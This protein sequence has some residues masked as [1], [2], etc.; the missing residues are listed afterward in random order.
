MKTPLAN[1][2]KMFSIEILKM[3]KGFANAISCFILE[4]SNFFWCA[5]C[6]VHA[7]PICSMASPQSPIIPAETVA[8]LRELRTLYPETPFLTLG[9][10]VLWDEPVKAA[11]CRLCD[12]LELSGQVPPGARV[13]AGVHDTDYFAKLEGLAIKS[14]PFAVLRHNDGDTRGLWSAAGELSALF[15]AEIVPSRGDFT[16]ENIAFARAAR[17]YNGGVEALLNQ[18]TDAPLWRAI[19]HTEPHP[20][21]SADVQLRDILPALREQLRWGFRQSLNIN[22]CPPDFDDDEPCA[23]RD[24]ARAILG[25][26]EEFAVMHAEATLSDLYVDLIPKI[27]RLVR[28][29][30][31]CDL[32]TTTSL[33]LFRFNA[34]TA[35]LPR[36]GFVDIFLNPATREL[37]KRCYNQALGGSGIYTLDGFGEGAL[38][39]DV[40]IP[41]KG[42]GTLRLHEGNVIVETEPPIEICRDCDP[43][44][45]GALAALLE[46]EFGPD[47]ALVG[48]AVSLISMLSAEFI[49]VFHE[50]A[51]GYTSRTYKMNEALRSHG[52]ELNLHPM[53]RLKYETWNALAE[54]EAD[55]NLPPH[56]AKLWPGGRV[57]ASEF[58][59]TWLLKCDECDG[60]RARL[61]S[62]HKTE[63]LM[64]AL[65]DLSDEKWRAKKAEYEN[66]R[67]QLRALRAQIAPLEQ[68]RAQLQK[69]AHEAT[70]EA[71]NLEREKGDFFRAQI[72]PHKEAIRDLR[73]N[74]AARTN[75]LDEN[76][77]PRKLSKEERAQIAEFEAQESARET[78]LRAQIIESETQWRAFDAQIDAAQSAAR[79][80]RAQANIALEAQL[81]LEKSAAAMQPRARIEA[82]ESQAELARLLLVRDAIRASESLRQNNVRPT[83]WWLPMVSPDGKWF[84]AIATT[85]RARIEAL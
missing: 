56:L 36:F 52:I 16:R 62:C 48:K 43:H 23:A 21:I 84:D 29:G 20:L 12:S 49:F 24:V 15:G 76:G 26:V 60:V 37:A 10:T 68:Q 81:T 65:A 45:I 9:Q 11:F 31:T 17:A 14:Q 74:A 66:G 67:E 77:K 75:P 34:Q 59:A 63:D 13:V 38:P 39:F 70:R 2:T 30:A 42:R 18:E 4:P 71:Q 73:E 79:E 57:S 83:A 47:I 64:D 1:A 32:E 53:L 3:S 19:V 25:W 61:K 27:W 85:A 28:G 72:W 44:S 69:Q 41:G 78:E 82:L 58:A 22:G 40:V 54:V 46:G 8:A 50:K 55:F 51:S 80:S 35:S 33:D 7:S 5:A 6:P